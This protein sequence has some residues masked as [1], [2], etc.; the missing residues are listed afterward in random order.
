MPCVA[1]ISVMN[2]AHMVS[3]CVKRRPHEQVIVL[4]QVFHRSEYHNFVPF[5]HIVIV[6]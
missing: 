4:L 5:L 2:D 6:L 1:Q 3:T